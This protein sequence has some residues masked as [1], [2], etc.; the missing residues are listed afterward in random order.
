MS[1][2]LSNEKLSDERANTPQPFCHFHAAVDRAHLQTPYRRRTLPLTDDEEVAMVAK[3]VIAL[4]L[5]GMTPL[6]VFHIF[7]H[8]CPGLLSFLDV[9]AQ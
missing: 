5:V 3:Y 8:L 6:I 2:K 7:H 9:P 1:I 4:A